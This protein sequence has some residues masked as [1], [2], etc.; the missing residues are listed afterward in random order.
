M[1]SN[2]VVFIVS[3]YFC[4]LDEISGSLGDLTEE[5][6]VCTAD[7][8]AKLDCPLRTDYYMWAQK[9]CFEYALLLILNRSFSCRHACMWRTVEMFQ[10]R[11]RPIP[12]FFGK[13]P[14][15]SIST[16]IGPFV[17]LI[18]EPASTLFSLLNLCGCFW[19]LNEIWSKTPKNARMRMV[20]AGYAVVGI[21]CWI[22]SMTFHSR[23]FWLTEYLDYFAAGALIFYA[24]YACLM[25]TIP[26][27]QWNRNMWVFLLSS[28]NTV[29]SDRGWSSGQL[30]FYMLDMFT[31][32]L[33]ILRLIMDIICFVASD[34]LL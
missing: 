22:F 19:L 10:R 25:F 1:L 33:P 29:V 27:L 26:I 30:L 21:F 28:L 32:C 34:C 11:G 3:I 17:L 31:T 2:Y 18:Q 23:D 7:C 16:Q 15:S 20:W 6:Q 13:W 14:F 9:P 8:M 5:F 4:L 12:Q 24:F